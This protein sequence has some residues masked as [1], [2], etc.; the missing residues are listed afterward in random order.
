M[1]SSPPLKPILLF[2]PR[3]TETPEFADYG[4]GLVYY[5]GE[6]VE[7]EIGQGIGSKHIPE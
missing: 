7:S 2:V 6:T 3:R 5:V 1:S 4:R